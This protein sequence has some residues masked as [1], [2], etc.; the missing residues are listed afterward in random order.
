MNIR[1]AKEIPIENLLRQLGHEP[2]RQTRDQLWYL[3]P[4]RD[5]TTP[6]FKVNTSR[7]LW[8]D[9]GETKGGSGL[10]LVMKLGR[11]ESVKEALARIQELSGL[12]SPPPPKGKPPPRPQT[13]TEVEITDIGPVKARS[14]L[15]YLKDRGIDPRLAARYVK[16]IHYRRGDQDY[17]ALAFANE[18]GSY[19]LRTAGFKGS[20]GPKDLSILP[21]KPERVLVFEGLFDFLTAVTLAG[22]QPDAT[23]IVLNSVTMR[24]KAIQA[25]RELNPSSVELYRDRDD[26][27]EQL[28]TFFRQSLPGTEIV[29]KAESYPQHKDLNEWHMA[30]RAEHVSQRLR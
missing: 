7:N 26:A 10:D 19:E 14:L 3:S 1:Q 8:Y 17:F 2:V 11:L 5:E 20:L 15:T 30:V 24:D 4:F 28:L 22:K 12:A 16:E 13:A 25:I 21:G 18:S 23:V 6:S 9:F 27:G 29:D